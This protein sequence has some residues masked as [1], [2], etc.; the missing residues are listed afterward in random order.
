MASLD[1][2]SLLTNIHFK[3]TIKNCVNNLF[4][5]NFYS[6]KLSRKDFYDLL[7]LATTESYFIF[8]NKRFNQRDRVGMCSPLSPTLA[9][10]FF[11]I[12]SL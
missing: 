11:L 2:E 5:N 3:E 7:K 1:V 6:G 10:A 4:S 8:D 9:N 12:L